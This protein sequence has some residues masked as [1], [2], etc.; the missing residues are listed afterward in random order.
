MYEYGDYDLKLLLDD[1]APFLFKCLTSTQQEQTRWGQSGDYL[2]E[3]HG[4]T[5]RVDRFREKLK[6]AR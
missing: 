4:L 2:R 1:I 5:L 6:V 3:L